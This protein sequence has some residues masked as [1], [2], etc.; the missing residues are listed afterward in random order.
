MLS[1]SYF[2]LVGVDETVNSK[3]ITEFYQWEKEGFAPP[4]T[5]PQQEFLD[6]GKCSLQNQKK[7]YCVNISM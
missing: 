3:T 2:Y 4:V 6:H 7:I 5:K 1:E